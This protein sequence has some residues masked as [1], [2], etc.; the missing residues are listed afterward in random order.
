MEP[1]FEPLESVPEKILMLKVSLILLV[2]VSLK[3]LGDLQT[4]SVR[5][6]CIEFSSWAGQGILEAQTC[7]CPKRY[8]RLSLL[9]LQVRTSNLYLLCPVRALKVY[10]DRSSH[11]RKSLQLLV[12]FGAGRRGL[13]A[14]KHIRRPTMCAVCLHL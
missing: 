2:L 8:C 4:L 14:S 7:L 13:A 5:E 10:G 3:C 11:W 9:P 6:S 12:C 1:P